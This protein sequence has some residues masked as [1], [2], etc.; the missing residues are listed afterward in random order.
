MPWS[1]R[2]DAPAQSVLFPFLSPQQ[3]CS[4]LYRLW[5]T[6]FDPPVIIILVRNRNGQAYHQVSHEFLHVCCQFV[7][8]I[9]FNNRLPPP[10][11]LE[12]LHRIT[13]WYNKTLV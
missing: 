5:T 12:V 1:Q 8:A 11:Y 9:S 10:I 3:A 6:D 7:D 2:Y 13:C 4:V